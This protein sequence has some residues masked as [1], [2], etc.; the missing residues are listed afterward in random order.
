MHLE[1]KWF[2][3]WGFEWSLFEG[4]MR[5]VGFE[6]R[7]EEKNGRMDFSLKKKEVRQNGKTK[8]GFH[9]CCFLD[10]NSRAWCPW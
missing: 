5:V 10:C 2:G 9:S 4:R 3:C 1:G 7:R 8:D 6:R